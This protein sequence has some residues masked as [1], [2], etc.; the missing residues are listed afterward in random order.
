MK[1]CKHCN[2]KNK[3][4]AE[5]CAS[6]GGVDF[7][8]ICENCGSTF[9]TGMYC[10]TCGVRAGR[11]AQTC[12]E[13]GEVYFTRACPECGYTRSR[14]RAQAP[15]YS[16]PPPARKRVTFWTVVLWIYFWPILCL[17]YMWRSERVSDKVKYWVTGGFAALFVLPIMIGVIT[18]MVSPESVESSEPSRDTIVAESDDNSAELSRVSEQPEVTTTLEPTPA[19]TPEPT[20]APTPASEPTRAEGESGYVDADELNL[21]ADP[22]RDGDIIAEYTEGT[23]LEIL[24][25]SGDWYKVRIGGNT[26]YMAKEYVGKGSGGGSGGGSGSGGSRTEATPRPEVEQTVMPSDVEN[27]VYWV[28]EGKKYH[29][30][31]DC[32]TLRNSDVI[33]SGTIDEAISNGKDDGCGWCYD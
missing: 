28:E 15:V 32:S 11:S 6:C 5:T 8:Y 30:S 7:K 26:G 29:I 9:D 18:A 16:A 19:P 3:N 17:L 24:G 33:Y 13:C 27:A 23:E 25:E 22:S 2:R 31:S 10:P 12:P 14:P 21:R 4:S 1:Y 20:P